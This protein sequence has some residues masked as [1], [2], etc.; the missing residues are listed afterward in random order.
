MNEANWQQ[1]DWQ[2]LFYGE[3]YEKLLSIKDK[4][5]P[6]QLFYAHTAVGSDR[7]FQDHEK[8]GRLCRA[9]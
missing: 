9:P 1:P 5:D 8:G 7:W 2:H 4:Y 6:Q 3:N